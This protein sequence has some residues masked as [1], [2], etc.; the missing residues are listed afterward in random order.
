MPRIE[1]KSEFAAGNELVDAQHQQLVEFANLFFEAADS[2]KAPEIIRESFDLLIRYVENHFHDEETLY[3]EIGSVL[4]DD[5]RMEHRQLENEIQ[6]IR[7]LWESNV[8][9]FD[10]TIVQAIETW[11]ETRLLPHFIELDPAA[12]AAGAGRGKD[13]G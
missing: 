10:G 11:I 5:Q 3:R 13:N 6:A 2:G 9:D 7:Q 4:L 1:W 8:A 12:L